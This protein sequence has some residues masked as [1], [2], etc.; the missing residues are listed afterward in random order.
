MRRIKVLH[1]RDTHEIGG[2]GKTILETHRAIDPERF[3]LHLGVFLRHGEPEDSPIIAEA[4]R[5]D[6]PLHV[7]RGRYSFDL[8]M[9]SRVAD[10]VK[11]LKM[12][13]V[14]AHEVKS[15][16]IA[17][18]AARICTVPLI[19]TMHGWI[20][21]GFK[22]RCLTA[23][24]KQIVRGFDQ[25]IAVSRQIHDELRA[26]GIPQHRLKLVHNAIVIER[27]VRTG[28]SGAMAKLL[29]KAVKR[30]VIG[31]IGRLS[32]EKGHA[33][34]IEALALVKKAGQ[35]FMMVFIGDGPERGRLACQVEALG[36]ADSV[37]MPGYVR[38]P[39]ALMEEID[40]MV[41]PSHTEGLPNAAL[42]SLLMEIPVL[43][44][45][46]GGTPEVIDDR[47]T[48]RLV[49]SHSPQW[50]A[51][52]ILEYFADPDSWKQMALQGREMVKERFDFR[53]RTRKIEAIY[54]DVIKRVVV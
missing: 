18:L 48:G 13:I 21:N 12:D 50:L 10:L 46:V 52:A 23:L 7:I 33:D 32:A 53:A 22:Q 30:P 16:V 44:T 2:P 54:S 27:Y 15:D 19:T 26:H 34:L 24:D 1:L 31:S 40:L 29:G 3:E 11:T 42:E 20:G 4:R 28:K 49:P 17:L 39:Q 5:L 9:V 8:R 25:V 43:A 35:E 41:L 37:Y 14:H 45:S 47:Q 51:A 6:M 38:D 36:L